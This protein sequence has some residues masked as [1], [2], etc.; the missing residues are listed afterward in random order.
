MFDELWNTPP[1]LV[2]IQTS[3]SPLNC[4]TSYVVT[5]E[6]QKQE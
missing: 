2:N 1:I 6:M 5:R 4:A 3:Q